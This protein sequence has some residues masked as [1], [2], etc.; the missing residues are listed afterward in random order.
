M[1][2]AVEDGRP[3]QVWASREDDILANACARAERP[4]LRVED[5]FLRSRGLGA[6]LVPPLSL[7]QDDLGIYYDP[8]RKAGW[9]A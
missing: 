3:V 5:G 6:R 1:A 4:L 9:N 8:A 2:R 7:V